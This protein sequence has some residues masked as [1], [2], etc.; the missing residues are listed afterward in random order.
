MQLF[1]Y[2][3]K[4]LKV[5]L[6]VC[7]LYLTFWLRIQGVDRLPTGQFTENDAYLYHWQ[8][9]IIATHG[10]LPARDMHR[11][12]PLGRD[13]QQ[14]LSLYAY[15]IAYSHKILVPAFPEITRY[16]VQLYAPAV[17]FTFGFVVLILF[18]IYTYGATFA[19]CVGLILATI[20]GSIERSAF[21]F[22]DR[23]AWCWL[24]GTLAIIAYLAQMQ[25]KL[26]WLRYI[27]TAIS[28][29]FVYLGGLSWEGFGIFVWIPLAVEFWRFCSDD[30]D[31]HLAAYSLWVLMFVPLLYFQSPAYHNGYGYATYVAALMLV[32]PLVLLIL[33]VARRLLLKYIKALQTHGRTI[34]LGCIVIA[35][36]VGV[37]YLYLQSDAFETTAFALR[38]SKMMQTMSELVDPVFMYWVSRHGYIYAFG[39]IGLIGA[40]V[41]HWRLKSLPIAIA[42]TLFVETTFFREPLAR[43][44]GNPA[45]D[46][47]FIVSLILVCAT[48]IYTCLRETESP[49]E[50]ITIAM[51]TW[52]VIWVALA[53]GGKRYDF[54]I[55]LPLAFGTGMM[56]QGVATAV[57]YI[58]HHKKYTTDAFREKFKL[59]HIQRSTTVVLLGMLLFWIPTG[60]YAYR[61]VYAAY[62][63]PALP[64]NEHVT[65]SYF[66]I[67]NALVRKSEDPDKIVMAA[68]WTFGS[69][70]NVLAGVKTINDQDTFL[71]HWITL[72]D[73]YLHETKS[74]RE[75]LEFLKTHH[76]THLMLTPL[77]PHNSSL[78]KGLSTA[79]VPVYPTVKFDRA[80]VKIW[81]INYPAEIAPDEKY[82]RTEPD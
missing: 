58:L 19:F 78:R 66:W 44:I 50:H 9:E 22:G 70:L 48:G 33:R 26:T 3:R 25:I 65:R 54:F 52:F 27:V 55:G 5:V 11:W 57:S 71:P 77:D 43:F 21:G 10:H 68:S 37:V 36:T 73:R 53:R 13:N 34:T 56:I 62:I 7:L 6:F 59:R 29:I 63:R 20:P 81:E 16:Q 69:Q 51:L 42:L 2:F 23:D 45:C 46:T 76:V 60:G 75:H 8:A 80:P 18:L 4:S 31:P 72:Y 28:G 17:C 1:V 79:F 30:K 47:L 64:M 12:V 82:I 67:R 74:E 39:S 40:C 38:E 14:L 49:H 61:S 35:I 41:Y 15:M 32:P 24:L